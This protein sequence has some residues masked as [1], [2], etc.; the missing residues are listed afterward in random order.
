MTGLQDRLMLEL[1]S[2]KHENYMHFLKNEILDLIK[3]GESD[4][5]S[6]VKGDINRKEKWEFPVSVIREAITFSPDHG[7]SPRGELPW[8]TL[9]PSSDNYSDTGGKWKNS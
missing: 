8:L 9:T 3:N 1:V 4:G 2:A 5:K 6:S 7:S